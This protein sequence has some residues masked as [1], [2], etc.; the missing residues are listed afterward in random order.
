MDRP[1]LRARGGMDAAPHV[2]LQNKLAAAEAAVQAL[3]AE[4]QEPDV[5]AT[6][7][8]LAC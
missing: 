8:V 2:R 3:L 4:C 6:L 7:E 1:R 5:V